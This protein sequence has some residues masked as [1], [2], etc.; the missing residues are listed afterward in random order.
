MSVVFTR[1]PDLPEGVKNGVAAENGHTLYAGLGSAGKRFFFLELNNLEK[2]WQRA[3]DF[4]GVERSDAVSI[5]DSKGMWVFSGAGVPENSGHAQVLEDV[6][7]FDFAQQSW[8]QIDTTTPVGLL[9]GSGCRLADDKFVF[10]GGYNKQTFDVFCQKMSTIDADKQ[11]EQRQILLSEFMSQK[12]QQYGWNTEIIAYNPQQNQWQ[13]LQENPFS[14]NCGA[15]LIAEGNK[16]T[17]VDGEIKPGLRSTEVKQF[18]FQSTKDV[19]C[20]LLPSIDG[21][22][23]QPEHEGLAGAFSGQI[24]GCGFA[25]GGAYF[26]GSQRNLRDGQWYTH[27]G[28]TKYYSSDVWRLDGSWK[29]VAQLPE[30]AAYGAAVTTDEGIIL[31]GGEQSQQ[32][33]LVSCYLMKWI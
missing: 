28:L 29:K 23:G 12:P 17:L 11:P 5:A 7:R 6:F 16:V 24:N 14:A 20:K 21:G 31:I 30:G 4:P 13:V 32:K 3:P 26:I 1:L 10:F 25:M 9:G 27:Q 22:S 8:T 15:A 33:A 19:V 18:T 2:G